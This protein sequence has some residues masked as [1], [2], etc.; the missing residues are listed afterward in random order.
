MPFDPI[1][2]AKRMRSQN[3]RE[4][5]EIERRATEAIEIARNL[6]LDIGSQV[7]G[8]KRVVLFGSLAEGVPRRLDFDIDLAIEG[9]DI[10]LAMDVIEGCD[11]DVDLVDISRVAAH[12]RR[13]IDEKGI[14]LFRNDG[15]GR[16][17][18]HR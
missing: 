2:A 15:K 12:I 18:S 3:R 11:I 4:E 6:A 13:R 14:E 10:Y 5:I 16:S 17:I 9:G 1:A 8:V 7:F